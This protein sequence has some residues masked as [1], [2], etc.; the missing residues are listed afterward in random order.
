MPQP[1][2]CPFCGNAS[3]IAFEEHTWRISEGGRSF[4]FAECGTCHT[5]FCTPTPTPEEIK[6]VYTHYYT[7]YYEWFRLHKL[8]KRIQARHRFSRVMRCLHQTADAPS[9][10]NWLDVGCGHGWFLELA[11]KNGWQAYG[12]DFLA[13]EIVQSMVEKGIHIHNGSLESSSWPKDSFGIITMWHVLEH[14]RDPKNALRIV[15]ELI[16]PGGFL[17]LAVPNRESKGLE[18]AGEQWTWLQEPFIHVHLFSTHAIKSIIP[19]NLKIV[20]VTSRDTW[21]QQYIQYTLPF[22]IYRSLLRI[23]VSGPAYV[24][25]KLRIQQLSSLFRRINWILF[26]SALLITYAGY[27]LGRP[28]FR[29]YEKSLRASELLVV[30][31][32]I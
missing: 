14:L 32:R 7:I 21:D 13:D 1:E 11:K 3:S 15:S 28:L 30:A 27:V 24:L 29:S 10:T 6:E 31:K 17:I 2:K 19:A 5:L 20:A 16:T 22:S 26:E 8:M 23:L 9:P 4:Q 25:E 18:K 12:I